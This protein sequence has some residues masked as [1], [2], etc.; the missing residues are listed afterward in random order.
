MILSWTF[1]VLFCMVRYKE[2][3]DFQVSDEGRVP[4]DLLPDDV[5]AIMAQSTTPVCPICNKDCTN[6]PNLRSH[7]Q[8]K[9]LKTKTSQLKLIFQVHNNIRPYACTFCE[10][11][12]ARVSHLNRHIRTHTGERP[13]ACE[14]CGKS[15]ARQD[16]LKL[17]MDRHLGLGSPGSDSKSELLGLLGGLGGTINEPPRK[18]SKAEKAKQD[19]NQTS[20]TSTSTSPYSSMLTGSSAP[21]MVGSSSSPLWGGFPLYSQHQ[22]PY[23]TMYPGK[24]TAPWVSIIFIFLGMVYPGMNHQGIKP[25]AGT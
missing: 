1:P 16:K 10:A 22:P 7:L 6:F 13:F 25:L 15:F 9:T 17:H 2:Q 8:V 11:K 20:I 4:L 21:T 3:I 14:R 18:K 24:Q 12:F 5:N 19:G 23:Q